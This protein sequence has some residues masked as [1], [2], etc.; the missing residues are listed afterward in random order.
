LDKIQIIEK[1]FTYILIY[2]YLL[3]PLFFF[4][5]KKKSISKESV[6]IVIYGVVFFILLKAFPSVPFGFRQLYNTIFTF[7]EYSFFSFF[8]YSHIQSKIFKR[9]IIG[10]SVIFIAFQIVFF[11]VTRF[12]R[13]DSLPIGI[14]TIFLSVFIIYFFYEQ[15]KSQKNQYLYNHAGFWLSIGILTYLGGLF[16]YN[17]LI[18]ELT[19]EQVQQYEP[20]TYIGD[21]VKNI[22]FS[23]GLVILVKQPK[24]KLP[25]ESALP[26]LDLDI[27]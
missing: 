21:V 4:V 24:K 3:P 1:L 18:T 14:E 10:F 22:F 16:F 2:S 17:I 20:F 5:R 15:F 27:N 9:V 23:I 8:V 11:S 6:S 25:R 19:R 26:F 7:L 12:V 13:L